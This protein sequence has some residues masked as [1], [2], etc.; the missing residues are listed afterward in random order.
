MI[1]QLWSVH[2]PLILFLEH[3]HYFTQK[4]FCAYLHMREL[5]YVGEELFISVMDLFAEFAFVF[6]IFVSCKYN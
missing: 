1:L 3:S 5:Y 2:T 4:Y 6:L